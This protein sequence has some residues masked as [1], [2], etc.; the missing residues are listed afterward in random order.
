MRKLFV[1]GIVS[2]VV[3]IAWLLFLNLD[4]K[5]FESETSVDPVPQQDSKNGS[6]KGFVQNENTHEPLENAEKSIQSTESPESV[7]PVNNT[8]TDKG[9]TASVVNPDDPQQTP[10]DT[11][12]LPE[13]IKLYKA[14]RSIAKE[15]KKYSGEQLA[16][17]QNQF[18]LSDKRTKEIQNQ[19]NSGPLV[20]SGP[21]DRATIIVMA[22]E[23]KTITAW[24]NE[25]FPRISELQNKVRQINEQQLSNLKEYGYSSFEEFWNTHWK[26]YETWESEQTNE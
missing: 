22:E 5:R 16:P 24:K 17:L 10:T 4:M 12:L 20:N 25:N 23:L 9:D 13:T 18:V 26:T 21:L 14:Y 11:A 6:N 7:T 19:M 1:V 2:V 3:L 8:D 15:M